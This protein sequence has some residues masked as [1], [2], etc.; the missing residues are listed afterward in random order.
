MQQN[1]TPSSGGQ[2][3][4]LIQQASPPPAMST[5]LTQPN[6]VSSSSAPMTNQ[7]TPVPNMSNPSD[8]MP[9]QP[10]PQVPGPGVP[11]QPGSMLPRPPDVMGSSSPMPGQIPGMT[12]GGDQQLGTSQAVVSSGPPQGGFPGT[13][14][15]SMSL[16]A[17]KPSDIQQDSSDQS[18]LK[19]PGEEPLESGPATED[20]QTPPGGK[21]KRAYRKK[22]PKEPKEPKEPK[23]K[24]EP[25]EPKEPKTPKT[26]TPRKKKVKNYKEDDLD[27]DPLLE[28]AGEIKQAAADST[29]GDATENAEVEKPEK[30]KKEKKAPKPKTPRPRPPKKKKKL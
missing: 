16:D 29:E 20:G 1:S 9:G 15:D 10:V 5:P 22:T 17:S 11:G 24:K 27:V 6:Q 28:E 18:S 14:P 19:P 23:K 12:P 26:R 3:A 21:K 4:Q 13:A 8:I 2:L 25:K 7:G 30:P